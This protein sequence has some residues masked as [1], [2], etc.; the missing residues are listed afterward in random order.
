MHVKVA[1]LV[2]ESKD[3]WKDAVSI[4]VGEASQKLGNITGVEVVNF[5]ANVDN[6]KVV[7]YKANVK[8]AYVE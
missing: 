8:V 6:G 7:E 4:A 3:G 5:T 2:G 1:E